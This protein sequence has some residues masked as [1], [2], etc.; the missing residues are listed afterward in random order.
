MLE[1]HFYLISRVFEESSEE[2]SNWHYP[3]CHFHESL[4]TKKR[5]LEDGL[6]EVEEELGKRKKPLR[7]PI[8]PKLGDMNQ[9]LDNS[10]YNNPNILSR[11]PGDL[12][13]TCFL[14]LSRSDYGAIAS[15]NRTFH[16][17]IQDLYKLRRRQGI[18]E[19]WIYFSC[20]ALQWQAFDP[21]CRRWIKV[22]QMP[23]SLTETF[24]FSDKESLAVGTDL[25]VFG[26][27]MTS[28]VVLRYSI[29]SN[30]WSPG[31]VMNSPRC[32][33]GSA[34][35]GGKAI[36]AGGITNNGEILNSVEL[37]DSETRTWEALPPMNRARK[38][39]SG[40][41][42]DDQFYVIG[43]MANE[44]EVLTCGER[45]DM[46]RG[47]WQLIPNMSAGLSGEHGAPP[48]VAVVN[49][50]LY[51]ARY[52]DNIVM[53]YNKEKNTWKGLGKLPERSDSMNGWG[54][55]FRACGER[56][57]V[58]GRRG[59][60]GGMIELNSCVPNGGKTEW[61]TIAVM[62]SADFVFNC[63]VMGC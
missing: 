37:Y 8:S 32:L 31:V 23:A 43:G 60:R 1:D 7:Q 30:S 62:Q 49:N 39:C 18:M 6:A 14:H 35:L 63:A 47:S 52:A 41:F 20:T 24:T 40:V 58:I 9:P 4:N 59:P 12:I 56:L 2:E 28:S 34:S 36:I 5:V 61:K 25:L 17:M 3:A 51:A 42:M 45:Y 46:K 15:V 27:E 44:R 33:F 21:Y 38:M 13:M 29:L 16:S 57:I 53:K 55:A 48:L 10:A 50:V 11:L 54:I 26:R 22:P 19:H